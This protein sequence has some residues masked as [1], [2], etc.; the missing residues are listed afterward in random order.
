LYTEWETE[1]SGDKNEGRLDA[2]D[3]REGKYQLESSEELAEGSIFGACCAGSYFRNFCSYL[4]QERSSFLAAL[5]HNFIQSHAI[6]WFSK[7]FKEFEK[8]GE[9][10]VV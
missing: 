10:G 2:D 6:F 1:E 5:L 3:D 8:Q 9:L 4:L 7:S